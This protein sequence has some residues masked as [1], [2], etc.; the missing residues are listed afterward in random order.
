VNDLLLAQ[1]DS[2]LRTVID[3]ELGIDIVSLGLIDGVTV[4]DNAMEIVMTLTTP[5]CPM[6]ATISADVE[7]TL[8][9]GARALKV[10][11]PRPKPSEAKA[12]RRLSQRRESEWNMVR[13]EYRERFAKWIPSALE[14]LAKEPPDY[15]AVMPQMPLPSS[16][17]AA[18]AYATG[19]LRI[20]LLSSSGAYDP[21]NQAPFAASSIVGDPTHRVLDI[22]LPAERFVFA[23]EHFD[24][25]S[26]QSDLE[27]IIP[28]GTLGSLGEETARH[29]IS[30]S[31][32]LLDWPTFIEATL[33]QIVKQVHID[34]SNAAII[35]P[36]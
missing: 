26:A 28:R 23:H 27:C 30:W 2:A 11:E 21:N 8:R 25:A 35:V 17:N 4:K 16:K 20:S 10:P 3:P 29:I 12:L 34:R 22:D 15:A 1:I 24:H 7:E 13:N 6:H 14:A 36:L 5:G 32:F 19:P 18:L 33:P 9:R 31:G